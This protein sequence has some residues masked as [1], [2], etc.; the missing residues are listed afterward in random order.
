MPSPVSARQ[1]VFL[2]RRVGLQRRQ[3]KALP[4]ERQSDA[5]QVRGPLP[6]AEPRVGSTGRRFLCE[7]IRINWRT[8]SSF[9]I[10]RVFLAAET[11]DSASVLCMPAAVA[12]SRTC[13]RFPCVRF[14]FAGSRRVGR[15]FHDIAT[16]DQLR[17]TRS[18]WTRVHLE[19]S[20]ALPRLEA[21]W[22]GTVFIPAYLPRQGCSAGVAD[23]TFLMCSF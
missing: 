4:K 9:L 12:N 23:G 19:Y 21:T 22:C 11:A 15:K 14:A 18:G 16:C 5:A 8:I 13:V 17:K 1:G 10:R 20:S 2:Q 7:C 3:P 6:H